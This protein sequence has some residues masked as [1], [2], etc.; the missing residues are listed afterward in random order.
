MRQFAFYHHVG[1]G[2]KGC[3]ALVRSTS[4]LL[5]GKEPCDIRLYSMHPQEDEASA[6][7][8]ISQITGVYFDEAHLQKPLSYADKIRLKLLRMRSVYAPSGGSTA[9]MCRSRWTRRVCFCPSAAIPI[10]TGTTAICTHST[11]A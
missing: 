2:N 6:Y 8:N 1:S 5:C 3:E 4:D 11:P 7:P 10:A 9:R